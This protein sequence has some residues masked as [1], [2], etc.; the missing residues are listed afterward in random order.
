M[1]KILPFIFF[2]STNF[3]IY[4]LKEI[5]KK[6]KPLLVVTLPAKRKERGLK[7]KPNE[8]YNFALKEK[9]PVIELKEWEDFKK[10]INL[11]KPLMG[12][13]A[14]FG[15]II[16]KEIIELFPKGILNIHPSLLP[17]YRGPSPIQQT[18]LNGEKYSGIT[19]ILIDELV[20][21]GPIIAQ[22]AIELK[23]NEDY[24][25]LEEIL[26]KLGG[27]KFNQ[28][29]EDYLEGKIEPT[30][31]DHSRATYTK[32]INFE[33]GYLNINDDYEIWQRK[34]RALN[35]EP[36]TYIYINLKGEKKLLKIFKIE[37]IDEKLIDEKTKKLNIG[38]FFKFKNYLAI[39][40]KDAF[41]LIL[42]LQLQDRKK[43][44]SKEFL[45]GYPLETFSINSY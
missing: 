12:L 27:F 45:N 18:I 3:S 19:I 30:K 41:V 35:P 21:H 6:Y 37:K 17:K 4:V 9:L 29:I 33:D 13:I 11:V 15:K 34:I 43:M 42:E 24:L 31:Q 10:E 23:G 25:K 44:N 26:G 5:L 38:E 7:L 1:K 40:I 8:V 14:G 39:K 36:G 2:G 22:E 28:I 16:P 32:K 20:D